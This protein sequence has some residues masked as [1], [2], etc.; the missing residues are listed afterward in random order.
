MTISADHGLENAQHL[1]AAKGLPC[2]E[3]SYLPATSGQDVGLKNGTYGKSEKSTKRAEN[4]E[5][6]GEVGSQE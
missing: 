3:C 6:V 2:R 4:Q 1:R 5:I